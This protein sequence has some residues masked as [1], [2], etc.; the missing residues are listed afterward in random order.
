MF[1]GEEIN[2]ISHEKGF[3]SE[4]LL[5]LGANLV[6]SDNV[7]S[8]PGD[9]ELDSD[10]N[11]PIGARLFSLRDKQA[12]KIPSSIVP[13]KNAV[14]KCKGNFEPP[15]STVLHPISVD[16]IS[17]ENLVPAN[18]EASFELPSSHECSENP[19]VLEPGSSSAPPAKVT[20]T[21]QKFLDLGPTKYFACPK[22]LKVLLP[23]SEC[24]HEAGRHDL[25]LMEALDS[26]EFVNLPELMI[27]HMT[28][29][30]NPDQ[31]AHGMLFGYFLSRIFTYFE[32]SCGKGKACTKQEMIR[33]ST[34]EECGFGEHGA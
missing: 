23:R 19:S 29:V 10:D 2:L 18:S 25:C 32:V 9:A 4:D 5:P 11:V 17:D 13:S 8:T 26:H 14:Q 21:M 31:G 33:A 24:R 12:Q 20:K 34:L 6:M 27:K 1:S 15:P 22:A 16:D 30:I 3:R 7:N 28:R